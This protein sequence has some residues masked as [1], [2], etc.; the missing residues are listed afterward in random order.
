MTK[1]GLNLW[2]RLLNR[3]S[4]TQV[5]DEC[6][7]WLWTGTR[8][9]GY[10]TLTVNGRPGQKAHRLAYQEFVGLIPDDMHVLHRCDNRA[11]INPAH[12]FLGTNGDNVADK[13]KKGRQ[14]RG[15]GTGRAKLTP[16]LVNRIRM[17]RGTQREIAK[18]FGIGKSQVHL[19]KTGQAWKHLTPP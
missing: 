14:S 4:I 16:E 9:N 6:S 3:V 13:V 10:G 1:H 15:A 8:V 5:T 19:I 17:A 11:C 12:L 7:C 2:E 18:L